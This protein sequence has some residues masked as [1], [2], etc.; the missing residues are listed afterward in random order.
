MAVWYPPFKRGI[1]V[2]V[3]GIGLTITAPIHIAIAGIVR[4]KLG[5]PALFRQVRPGRNGH[6]FVLVKFR[7][8]READPTRGVVDDAERM[9]PLGRVLR[10]TSLDELPTLWNVFRGDMS[11]VGPRPLLME[12]LALYS[13]EQARRHE[14]R[15]GIT[16]LAQVN[17]RNSAGWNERFSMDVEYVDNFTL[18]LDVK[19]IIRTLWTV[20]KRDGISADGHETMPRFSGTAG[21]L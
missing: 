12:Y 20:M 19:I 2:V 16:G 6:P 8:M 7:T 18:G 17:G 4:W 13:D 3:A 14:V 15:P 9:T 21:R 1:D 11:I 5:P 10:S